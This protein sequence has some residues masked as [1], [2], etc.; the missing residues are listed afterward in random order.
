MTIESISPDHARKAME[1]G[2]RLIDIRDADEHARAHVPGAAN[3]PLS[4]I[5][6]LI[7]D[8][9][10]V[11]FYCRSGRRTSE[12]AGT[13]LA[14]AGGTECYLLD[15]GLEAWQRAGLPTHIDPGQPLEIMRQVQIAAGMLVLTGV[16][17][18]LLVTPVFFGLSAFVGAGLTFAGIS[19]WCG[20][21]SLLRV[22]P[23][24]RRAAA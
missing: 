14:A 16:A 3:L 5:N 19:G 12:H 8:G 13:L 15:G 22:M 20:M 2:A 17:L 21:A 9:R 24:N 7:A 1:S 10:P 23:W 6:E 18:G 4:R 11:V